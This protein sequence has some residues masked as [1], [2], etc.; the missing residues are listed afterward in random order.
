MVRRLRGLKRGHPGNTF[1]RV[2]P[3]GRYDNELRPAIYMS[4]YIKNDPST[5]KTSYPVLRDILV[6]GNRFLDCPGAVL[7]ACSVQNLMVRNNRI[8]NALAYPTALPYRGAL[9]VAYVSN[10]FVTANT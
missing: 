7:F 6:E 2:N 5:E 1:H 8:E 10:I 3:A 9:G 4:T